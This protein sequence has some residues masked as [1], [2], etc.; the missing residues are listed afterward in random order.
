MSYSRWGSSRWYTFW[1]SVGSSDMEFKLPTRKLKYNQTFEICD[2]PSYFL[3]YEDIE[4]KGIKAILEEVKEVYSRDQT[5]P[6]VED[7]VDGKFIFKKQVCSPIPP[8]WEELKEL[9]DYIFEFKKDIDNH[10]K[11]INFIKYEWYYPLR[12]KII[13]Y[14]KNRSKQITHIQ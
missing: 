2:I 14:V 6:F 7:T 1:S 12:N 5:L 13:N 9:Q 8:N 10:F 11:L 4:V 3:T